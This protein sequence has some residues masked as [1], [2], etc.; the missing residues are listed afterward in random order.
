MSLVQANK[1]VMK[2]FFTPFSSHFLLQDDH[3]YLFQG[4]IVT[5]PPFL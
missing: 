2:N 1:L 3:I 5:L 4:I